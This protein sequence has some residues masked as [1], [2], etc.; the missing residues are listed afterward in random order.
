MLLAGG[1]TAATIFKVRPE[2]NESASRHSALCTYNLADLS[3]PRR[4]G[5]LLQAIERVSTE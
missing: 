5:I 4:L 2:M 1:I 3:L